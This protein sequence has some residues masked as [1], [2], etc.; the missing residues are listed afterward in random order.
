MCRWKFEPV[1]HPTDNHAVLKLGEIVGFPK[2][3]N[4]PSPTPLA[5][6]SRIDCVRTLLT[7]GAATGGQ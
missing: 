4:E 5:S 3:K 7:C 1:R 6:G 2:P